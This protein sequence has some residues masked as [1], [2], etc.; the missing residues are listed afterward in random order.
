MTKAKEAKAPILYDSR[1]AQRIPFKLERGGKSYPMAHV[2]G[3]LS[4]ERYFTFEASL[5]Q[6]ASKVKKATTGIYTPKH[7]LWFDLV[8]AREGYK[9]T[10]PDWKK[11]T[12]QSDAIGAIN[13]LLH[14]QVLDDSELEVDDSIGELFD[15]DAATPISF[16]ALQAGVLMTLSHSFRPETQAEMDEFLAIATNEPLPNVLASAEKLSKAEKLYNLGSKLLAEREGYAEGSDIPP[17][18]LAATT[19][20]FFLRQMGRMGKSLQP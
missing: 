11:D 5:E 19:E 13:A 3:P 17:W 4:D 15:E 9:K 16:R 1:I 18:H 8:E 10:G 2:L 14:A 20:S 12:H 6:M 7:A